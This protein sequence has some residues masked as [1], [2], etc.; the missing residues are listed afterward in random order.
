MQLQHALP[1]VRGVTSD[2]EDSTSEVDSVRFSG[3]TMDRITVDCRGELG[4]S[5]SMEL[6]LERDMGDNSEETELRRRG[7]KEK[8]SGDNSREETPSESGEI[9]RVSIRGLDVTRDKGLWEVDIL[10]C[11]G[12]FIRIASNVKFGAVF[13]S[14]YRMTSS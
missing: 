8:D 14:R 4:R 13:W 5:V 12:E 9:V 2:E 6:H 10:F 3:V 1:G 7:N 11:F